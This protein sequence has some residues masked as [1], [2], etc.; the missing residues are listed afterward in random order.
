MIRNLF[1]ALSGLSVKT[2]K[3]APRLSP[4]VWFY[5]RESGAAHFEIHHKASAQRFHVSEMTS[6][7]TD[8]AAASELAKP[9]DARLMRGFPVSTRVNHVANDDEECSAPVE[10]AEVQ[11]RPFS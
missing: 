11:D 7:K 4:R 8:V 2:K 10:L 6:G 9:Y 1:R 3:A 5:E